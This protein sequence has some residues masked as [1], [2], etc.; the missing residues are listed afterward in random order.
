MPKMSDD[1][2]IRTLTEG[3]DLLMNYSRLIAL[4]PIDDWLEALE[5]AETVAPFVD[6]TMYR[7]Y[8]Y[9]GKSDVIKKIMRSALELK[10]TMEEIQPQVREMMQKGLH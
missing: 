2:A 10:R 5:K 9:S 6:P 1:E 8:L 7:S 3:W 4:L